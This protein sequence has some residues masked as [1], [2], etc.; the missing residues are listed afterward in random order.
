MLSSGWCILKLFRCND[1]FSLYEHMSTLANCCWRKTLLILLN[2]AH[3]SHR[4]MRSVLSHFMLWYNADFLFNRHSVFQ[5]YANNIPYTLMNSHIGNITNSFHICYVI[6]NYNMSTSK[7]IIMTEYCCT[8]FAFICL[9][10]QPFVQGLNTYKAIPRR[11][12]RQETVVAKSSCYDVYVSDLNTYVTHW[13]KQQVAYDCTP[14]RLQPF[15]KT[16]GR[17]QSS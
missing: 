15:I 16:N 2:R 12:E 4:W 11:T 10:K 9:P 13:M 1:E 8:W 5:W 17:S 3:L 7:L 14:I 6:F